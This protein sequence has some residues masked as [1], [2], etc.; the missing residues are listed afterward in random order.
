MK[1]DRWARVSWSDPGRDLENQCHVHMCGQNGV[2]GCG[3]K[4]NSIHGG[5]NNT[6]PQDRQGLSGSGVQDKR[7]S[8]LMRSSV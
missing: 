5:L 3:R 4:D 6:G 7:N 8:L 2:G 1:I